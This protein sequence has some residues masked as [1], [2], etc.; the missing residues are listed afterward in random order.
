MKQINKCKDC[1]LRYDN[2]YLYRISGEYYCEFCVNKR[3]MDVYKRIE[4]GLLC[5]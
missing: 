1:G 2:H 4:E 5:K 3:N